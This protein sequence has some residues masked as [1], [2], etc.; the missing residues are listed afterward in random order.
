MQAETT[1]AKKYLVWRARLVPAWSG[2]WEAVDP[3]QIALRICNRLGALVRMT[4]VQQALEA[5]AVE[6]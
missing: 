5:D 6:C 1:A 4:G 3:F 2:I